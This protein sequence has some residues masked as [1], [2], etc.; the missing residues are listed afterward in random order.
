MQKAARGA[1]MRKTRKTNC[2]RVEGLTP[3][4][5][6]ASKTTGDSPEEKEGIRD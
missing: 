5:L 2:G 6:R 3:R 4:E 1:T